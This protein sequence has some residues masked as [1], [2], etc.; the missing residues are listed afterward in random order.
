MYFLKFG[1]K[2]TSKCQ[3][4]C[5]RNFFFPNRSIPPC[6]KVVFGAKGVCLWLVDAAK[7]TIIINYAYIEFIVKNAVTFFDVLG[8]SKP[9]VK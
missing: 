6:V 2:E 1:K 3:Y 5:L 8:D 7:R 4:P 9:P